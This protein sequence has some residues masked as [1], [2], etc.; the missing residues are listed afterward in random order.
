V[1]LNAGGPVDSIDPDQIV[2]RD[3]HEWD[4]VLVIAIGGVLGAQARYGLGVALPH[5]SGSISWATL[6]IN[7]S[8][9]LGIGVLMAILTAQRHPHRLVRPF[10]GI[11]IL[12]G[13]TTYSSF[14][15]DV[16]GLVDHHRTGAAAGYL[17]LT[18]VG[19]ALAVWAATAAT[20]AVRHRILAA[21][22]SR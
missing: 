14:S 21:G 6:L 4:I 2:P 16:V 8:G 1:G 3:R 18:V 10:V 13:Y 22:D 17:A 11:G 19:C 5:T 15:T 9:C 20:R 7:V 12:G